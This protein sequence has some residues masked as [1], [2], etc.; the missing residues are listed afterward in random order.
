MKLTWLF[1]I[2]SITLSAFV[3][4]LRGQM[5]SNLRHEQFYKKV[6]VTYNLTGLSFNQRLE[7][8]LYCSDDSFT[9]SLSSLSGNGIGADV[10]GNG[11]KTIVWDVLKD[12][13]RLTGNIKFEIR[14]L[15]FNATAEKNTEAA[16]TTVAMTVDDHKNILYQE[17]SQTLTSYIVEGNDLVTAFRSTD[18]EIFDDP[19]AFRKITD[20]ILQ[21]NEAFNKLKN[22]RISYEKQ[23]L[24][25]WENEALYT[26]VRNLFDYALGDLHEVNVLGLNDVLHTINDINAEKIRG[27]KN[28]Q[29]AKQKVLSDIVKNTN[30]LDKRLQELDRRSTRMLY[31]LERR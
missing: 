1:I 7:V 3:I 24:K 13:K 29:E 8:N 15:P 10:R 18:A 26:D 4:D 25:Y 5:I 11:E 23:I 14:A 9:K 22:G 16:T 31:T 30:E 28:E 17:I 20:A 27:R 19:V 21:Y 2:F 6:I 12:R